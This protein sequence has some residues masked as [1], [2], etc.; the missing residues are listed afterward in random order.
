MLFQT[1]PFSRK[2]LVLSAVRRDSIFKL[3]NSSFKDSKKNKLSPH[4]F[5][6]TNRGSTPSQLT[7]SLKLTKFWSPMK[8]LINEFGGTGT[9]IVQNYLGVLASIP[10]IKG[11]WFNSNLSIVVKHSHNV[12]S[13]YAL[14]DATHNLMCYVQSGSKVYGSRSS[15]IST[16]HPT[17][18]LT[19]KL[20]G[21]SISLQQTM[22]VIGTPSKQHNKVSGLVSKVRGI[23]KNPVDHPNG[24]RANTKGSFKTPWGSY[25]KANK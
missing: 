21:G 24:G 16:F 15:V 13:L 2:K 7:F 4:K 5:K 1:R 9:I 14:Q 8:F 22:S 18:L 10:G 3:S 6:Q 23:A 19:L 25:A 17:G 20:K 12:L 11:Y